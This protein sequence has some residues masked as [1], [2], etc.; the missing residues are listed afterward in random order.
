VLPFA[1]SLLGGGTRTG[2]STRAESTTK[3]VETQNAVR[4]G[5]QKGRREGGRRAIGFIAIL[6][7]VK[8]RKAVAM[9]R[10]GAGER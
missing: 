5:M 6:Q 3:R 1:K 9:G 8:E 2:T 4:I 7:N 10:K